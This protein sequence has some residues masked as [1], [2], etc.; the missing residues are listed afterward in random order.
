MWE[1]LPLWPAQAS[2]MAGRVDALYLF[3]IF[4]TGSV[5]L[6]VWFVIFVLVVKYRHK[7][8]PKAEPIEGSTPLEIT[9]SVL[10]IFVF[11]VFYGWGAAIY[12]A[13]SRPPK[14]AMDVYVTGKQWMWKT[15]HVTGQREINELHV[16]AGR[17]V[18]LTMISQDV[19]HSFYIPAFRIKMDVMPGR[20]STEWFHATTPGKYHLF[21]AEYC[22]TQ[23]S[24]MI[25]WVTVME[26]RDF[27]A[28]LAGGSG[29]GSMA[30]T[31]SK[32]FQELGCATCHRFDVQGRGPNLMGIYGHEQLLADGRKIIV[33]DN[34]IRES[35]LNPNAKIVAGFQ[36]IMPTFN[37]IVSEDQLLSLIA[38]V[39]S[40][41]TAQGPNAP[42]TPAREPVPGTAQPQG[43]PGATGR[44]QPQQR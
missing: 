10:P 34:Y 31:G 13:E 29:E 37:G 4:V 12:F 15:Q 5:S 22:G 30:S 26:P 44:A 24:G 27:E 16:P 7:V 25:G 3:L 42:V 38:Y 43:G 20:Y 17:D 11:M 9:W 14:N 36:P 33:D 18:R 21:C 41:Q 8:H 39:K 6:L 28:W 19:I 1:N 35:I 23:H 32:L 2:T 40:L